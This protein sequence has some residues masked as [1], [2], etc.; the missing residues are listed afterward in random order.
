MG[1]PKRMILDEAYGELGLQGYVFDISPEEQQTALRRL[2]TMMA[3]WEA[4]GIRVG[5]AFPAGPGES[6]LDV[7]SGL[8]DMAVETVYLNLAIRLAA[9]KGKQLS[10]S[11]HSTAKEG[12]TTLLWRAATPIE[13]QMPST[14]PRGAGNRA[15][16]TEQP[17]FPPPDLNP[18]RV[19]QNGDLDFLE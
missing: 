17:F 8:P 3:T 4:K 9:G 6:D 10:Q 19:G 11:T 15:W 16:N 14:M 1:W 18:L 12:Y 2:D 7:D 5:Y 13:Q